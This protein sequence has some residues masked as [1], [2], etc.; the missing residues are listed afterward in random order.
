MS[1]ILFSPGILDGQDDQQPRV[2][3]LVTKFWDFQK[4]PLISCHLNQVQP[5]ALFSDT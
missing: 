3:W 2:A 1:L 4:V 5:N